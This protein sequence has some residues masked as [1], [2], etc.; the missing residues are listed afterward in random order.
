[1]RSVVER[2][3]KGGREMKCDECGKEKPELD[4]SGTDICNDCF[5]KAKGLIIGNTKV[6]VR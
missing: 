3:D 6:V 2:W 4:S 5:K 1:M